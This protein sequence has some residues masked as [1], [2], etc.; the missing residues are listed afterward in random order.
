MSQYKVHNLFP[1]PLFVH[2]DITTT[3]EQRDFVYNAEWYRPPADNGL[4]TKNTYLLDED[5]M[6]TFK[7]K[8]MKC[9][10]L[11]AQNELGLNKEMAFRMTNSWAVKH[12]TGDWGQSHVHTNS[13]LSGVYYM[14]TNEQTGNI[15]FHRDVN[16]HVLPLTARPGKYTKRN[17]YNT[18]VH[19][20][21]SITNR[22]VLF[23]SDVL[24]SVG[25]NASG[26]DRY[27][28][29]FNFFP[30]GTWGADEHELIL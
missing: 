9:V 14:D 1:K 20:V 26:W 7:D 25:N 22:L 28:I 15:N 4:L 18:D 2:D 5:V 12:E 17:D 21:D 27:S 11:Y 29:A 3:E 16:D 10:D 23:P 8:V 6:K 30:K 13:V 24:H 19:S